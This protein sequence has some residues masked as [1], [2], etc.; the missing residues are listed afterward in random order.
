MK[1]TMFQRA[2]SLRCATWRLAAQVR[3]IKKTR[4][5]SER[6]AVRSFLA[7]GQEDVP[8]VIKTRNRC[9]YA[10]WDIA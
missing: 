9:G 5:R 6:R 3:R 4:S 7:G 10:A 8:A 1:S 2:K